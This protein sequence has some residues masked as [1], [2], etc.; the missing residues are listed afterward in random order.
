MELSEA[1]GFQLYIPVGMM[2]SGW[3]LAT[4]GE[5]DEGLNQIEKG[6]AAYRATGSFIKY[7]EVMAMYSEALLKAGRTE[8]TVRALEEG[9]RHA[10]TRDEHLLESELYRIRGNIR[11]GQN[12]EVDAAEDLDRAIEIARSQGAVV[13]ELRA[14]MSKCHLLRRQGKKLEAQSELR[15]LYDALGDDFHEK[16]RLEA[17]SLLDELRV[18]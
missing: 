5:L 12:R 14:V 8:D 17:K 16:D 18:S 13:L 4:E 9:M 1:E 7:V 11:L 15:K 6:L 2:Y 3:A 10:D